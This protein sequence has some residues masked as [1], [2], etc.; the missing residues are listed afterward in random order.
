MIISLSLSCREP[1]KIIG[2][3][4]S[5]LYVTFGTFIFDS[6]KENLE[7]KERKRTGHHPYLATASLTIR[8][9]SRQPCPCSLRSVRPHV[10][11]A[12]GPCPH[13]GSADCREL[14]AS[15]RVLSRSRAGW[16]KTWIGDRLPSEFVRANL[17]M[18]LRRLVVIESRLALMNQAL[19][20]GRLSA[21]VENSGTLALSL[22]VVPHKTEATDIENTRDRESA[23]KLNFRSN[24]L[25]LLLSVLRRQTG[26]QLG[27][28]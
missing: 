23:V 12:V 13:P 28:T 11:I 7:G 8:W 20:S 5:T 24:L 21:V 15:G 1:K 22:G 27:A 6:K 2:H 26:R 25:F 19:V 10:A 3:A 14:S 4:K 16:G 9:A 17:E 18:I